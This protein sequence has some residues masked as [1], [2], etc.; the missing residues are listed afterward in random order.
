[1]HVPVTAVD[2]YDLSPS[3][4]CEIGFPRQVLSV[5]SEAIAH[6]MDE[7]PYGHFRLGILRAYGGHVAAALLG[8]V[9]ISH[10]TI[11]AE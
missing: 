11:P 9:D 2:K 1:V 5:Q 10:N 6:S 7:T 8:C 3:D 4:K